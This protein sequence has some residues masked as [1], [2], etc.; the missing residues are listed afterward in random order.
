MQQHIALLGLV[1]VVVLGYMAARENKRFDAT[2]RD[3][4]DETLVDEMW[5]EIEDGY[6]PN[7]FSCELDRRTKERRAAALVEKEA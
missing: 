7:P 6:Y 2:L 5:H 1:V 3:M 4:T